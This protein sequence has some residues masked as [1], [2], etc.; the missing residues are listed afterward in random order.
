MHKWL[1]FQENLPETPPRYS[2]LQ[3]VQISLRSELLSLSLKLFIL[4]QIVPKPFEKDRILKVAVAAVRSVLDIYT[5][6][7]YMMMNIYTLYAD[8]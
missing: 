5:S 8:I 2:S 6:I 1:T 7:H 4:F 3:G